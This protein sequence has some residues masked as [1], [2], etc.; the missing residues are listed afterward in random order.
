MRRKNEEGEKQGEVHR[1]EEGVMK[2]HSI[3]AGFVQGVHPTRSIL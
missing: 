1:V 3:M 2:D